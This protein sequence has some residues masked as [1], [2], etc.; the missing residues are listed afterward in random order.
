[1]KKADELRSVQFIDN[2]YPIIDGV[3]QTVNK[4]AEIMNRISYS[5]VV[6]PKAAKGYKDNFSYEVFRTSAIKIPFWEYSLP[7]P[8]VDFKLKKQLEERKPDIL[9]AHSP[10]TVG[11]YA[12]SLAKNMGIPSVATFHSKYYDDCIRITGSKQIA[13]AVTRKIVSFYSS[14]DSVWAVSKGTADT[15]HDY[16]YKGDIFVI[17]NG[18]DFVMPENPEEC[19]K[20]AREKFHIP[21]NKKILLF[22]GHQI[23]QKNLKLVLDT[24]RRLL[25]INDDYRLVV[26]GN[27]YNENN[28]KK[29]AEKLGIDKNRAIFTGRVTER[30]LLSGL[31]LCSDLFFFPSVYDNSPRV[32]REAAAMGL[33][34]LLTKGSNSAEA[35]IHN[36]SGFVAEE[37]A[38]AMKNEIERIFKTEGLLEYAGKNA[39]KTIPVPWEELIPE[40]YEKYAEIILH[41]NS[42]VIA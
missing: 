36:E 19:A 42:C 27:G 5:C 16:G 29:Y 35:V 30:R 11:T 13:E 39:M 32:V 9:H 24:Y 18:T 14:V 28:I 10:F 6:A 7:I 15:L 26:V 23:W 3:V 8:T 17:N 38:D 22:V 25:D 40:V 12:V 41:K 34:S 37:N 33:P 21:T 1:M 2:Y 31:F 4:Y 20:E